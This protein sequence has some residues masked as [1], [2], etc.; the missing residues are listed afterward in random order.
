MFPSGAAEPASGSDGVSRSALFTSPV[1]EG[2]AEK[3]DHLISGY[4]FYLNDL[5][6]I[7]MNDKWISYT[8]SAQQIIKVQ[9]SEFK[10][11]KI[12]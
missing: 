5:I 1:F 2:P 12:T 4:I 8:K 11:K 9:V 3:N 6:S 7:H 10:T